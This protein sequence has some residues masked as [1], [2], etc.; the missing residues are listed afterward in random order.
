MTSS[1]RKQLKQGRKEEKIELLQRN[2]EKN[3]FER[4]L[5]QGDQAEK[6]NRLIN[7]NS[8]VSQQS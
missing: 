2:G 3:L 7:T 1:D 4:W 8:I 6:Q 5:Q